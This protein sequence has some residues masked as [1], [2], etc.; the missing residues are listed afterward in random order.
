[1]NEKLSAHFTKDKIALTGSFRRQMETIDVLEWCVTASSH[2]LKKFFLETG[3]DAIEED[4]ETILFKGKENVKLKFYLVD[5]VSILQKAFSNKLQR[6]F[7]NRLGK[8]I[9]SFSSKPPVKRRFLK[10]RGCR[11]LF[12]H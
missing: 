12:L 9:S 2:D 10:R 11:L 3:V 1:M 7:L 8:T 6:R 5:E 4:A